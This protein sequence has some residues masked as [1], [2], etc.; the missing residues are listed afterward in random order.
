[1]A[2]SA[3]RFSTMYNSGKLLLRRNPKRALGKDSCGTGGMGA[4]RRRTKCRA[5]LRNHRPL[6]QKNA[7]LADGKTKG[8][9]RR[10]VIVERSL[11]WINNFRHL[12][13]DYEISVCSAQ[14]VCTIVAFRTL[15]KRF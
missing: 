8:R 1:M 12:S 3:S 11:A 5:Q 15:L 2:K 10:I 6:P 7:G 4:D 14:A 9:E 13:K